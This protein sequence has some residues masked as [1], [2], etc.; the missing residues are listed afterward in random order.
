MALKE[1]F[2]QQGDLLF[3]YR[4]ILPLAILILGVLTVLLSG[5]SGDGWG[6]FEGGWTE[7]I[8]LIL[9]STGVIG[10]GWTVGHTPKGTSGRNRQGQLADR[11]NTT[12][13][14][15]LV[16]H[17]LYVANFMI[18]TGLA[19]LTAHPWFVVLFVMLF[20]LYY[21]R[22]MFMEEKFLRD[23]FGDAFMAWAAVTPAFLPRFRAWARPDTAFNW[24]KVL[25][26]EKSS[27]LSTFTVFFLIASLSRS[28]EKERF[29]LADDWVLALFVLSV[30]LY[31]ILKALAKLTAVLRERSTETNDPD[32]SE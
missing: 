28:V 24:K 2:E 31:G 13:P 11:L 32:G 30:L 8:A 23:K 7:F 25:K 22:I 10:R 21:E 29:H 26:R 17:P 4:G 14:Y 20:A 15:S 5:G 27:F 3:R 6:F 1:E 18:W 12:G 16:R 9:C 19:L